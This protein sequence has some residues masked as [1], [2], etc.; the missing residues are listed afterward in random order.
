[1]N[2]YIDFIEKNH[3]N[4]IKLEQSEKNKYY[5]DL[6]NLSNS[7]TGRIGVS[8]ANT[9]IQESTYL[10]INAISLFENGYFDCAYYSLRQSLEVSTTMNYLSELSPEVRNKKLDEWKTQKEFPMNGKMINFLKK[11]EDVYFDMFNNMEEYFD[12]LKTTK[13]K[14]NKF[15]HKQGYQYFY[16]SRNHPLSKKDTETN[17]LKE[18]L[19]YLKICIGAVAVFRLVI[20]PMPILLMDKE[21][22]LRTEDLLTMPFN[23]DFIEEYIGSN[24]IDNYMKTKVYKEHHHDIMKL[25]KQSEYINW[26]KKDNFIDKN[27]TKEILEQKHLLN[28][29]EYIIVYICDVIK[30]IAK[31]Y[32][33]GGLNMY[34][35]DLKTIRRKYEWSTKFYT[36]LSQKE[37]PINYP[38]DEAYLSYFNFGEDLDIYLEHNEVLTKIEIDMIQS[39]KKNIIEN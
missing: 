38:F 29:Y 35:T 28:K 5:L 15:V 26:I 21:I 23:N 39:I 18:F 36:D 24:H 30:K 4:P 17:Y 34:F 2:N 11:N 9:F 8:F 14:L 33:I 32:T 10:L 13:N 22:Y 1:M 12:M 7:W 16:I 6:Q 20:D 3:I 25:E 31:I 19:E 37:F 27:K